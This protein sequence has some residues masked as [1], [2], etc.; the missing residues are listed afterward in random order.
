MINAHWAKERNKLA[1]DSFRGIPTKYNLK[2]TL[3][4]GVP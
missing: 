3:L 4:Y 2:K 1:V